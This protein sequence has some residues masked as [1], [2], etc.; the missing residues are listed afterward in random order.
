MEFLVQNLPS[1]G[2]GYDF[3]SINLKPMTYLN[4]VEYIENVPEDKLSKYL[5]DIR[6]VAN[7]DQNIYNCYIMDLDYLIFMKKLLTVSKD[8]VINVSIV[9]PKCGKKIEE[10]LSVNNLMFKAAD[11]A[12][13]EGAV[14]EIA[15]NTYSIK[16]PTVAEFEKVFANYLRYRKITDLDT[17]KL[18]S[19]VQEFSIRPNQVEDLIINAEYED[20]TMLMALKELY[21]DR[22]EPIKVYCDNCN[23]GRKKEERRYQ[24]VSVNSLIVDFFREIPRYNKL[25]ENKI[26]FKQTRKI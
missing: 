21:F 2:Y 9:C 24:T 8:L 3:P 20:I 22:V 12:V 7:D 10:K 25:N 11:E 23:K 14:V 15:G 13:M 26:K 18:I 1:G 19:L 16:P 5:F 4:T 6:W 17:I